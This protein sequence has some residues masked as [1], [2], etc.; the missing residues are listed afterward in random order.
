M[1][2]WKVTD[3]NCELGNAVIFADTRSKAIYL[4]KYFDDT[5]DDC[6]WVDMRARRFPEYDQY[7]SGKSV[8]DVWY[9]AEHMIRLVRD[10]GWKCIDPADSCEGDTCPAKEFCDYYA[11]IRNAPND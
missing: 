11:E 8:I 9:D 5:F 10:F 1:K 3:R 7:Y 4:A 6:E 2:A